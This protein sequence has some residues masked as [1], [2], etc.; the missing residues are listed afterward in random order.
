MPPKPDSDATSVCNRCGGP[1]TLRCS[2]CHAVA[3]C[4]KRHQQA[5]W[6]SHKP[7]C[8]YARKNK[9]ATASWD[10][11]VPQDG[12]V[13][14]LRWGPETTFTDLPEFQKGMVP[15]LSGWQDFFSTRLDDGGREEDA[16]V[17]LE[18]QM[19]DGLSFPVSFLWALRQ[20]LAMGVAGTQQALRRKRLIIGALGASDRAEERLLLCT[21]YWQE[22]GHMFP[23]SQVDLWLVGPEI[24]KVGSGK[25]ERVLPNMTVSRLRGTTAAFLDKFQGEN[26]LIVGF[27]TGFGSGDAALRHSWKG[28]L[29]RILQLNLLSIFTCANDYHDL[30]CERE[31][32]EKELRA[33]YVMYPRKNPFAAVTTTHLPGRQQD[34]WASANSFVYAVQ[35]AVGSSGPG[36]PP[37]VPAAVPAAGAEPRPGGSGGGAEEGEGEGEEEAAGE[38][39]PEEEDDGYDLEELD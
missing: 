12:Y 3:Y 26:P 16:K 31:I 15:A 38:G 28:D 23:G 24:S 2:A 9:S 18:P 13:G 17:V 20:L 32:W 11:H 30:K 19:I 6:K 37:E 33:Q 7:A 8:L 4:S 22:I 14:T 29:R 39:M 10:K 21:N 25:S 34:T 1:G 27:N 5:D 35:G 36:A